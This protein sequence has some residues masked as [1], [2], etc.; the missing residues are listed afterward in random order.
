MSYDEMFELE[1]ELQ[2][3]VKLGKFLKERLSLLWERYHNQ[4]LISI[5]LVGICLVITIW[6]LIPPF[7]DLSIDTSPGMI[8]QEPSL[9]HWLG[10]NDYG[11]DAFNLL[12]TAIRNSIGFGL[13][14]SFIS[15]SIA[16]IFGVIGPFKGGKT[17]TVF[18][19]I[20][21][22][23]LVFPIIPTIILIST[24]TEER[25]MILILLVIALFN[26]P[27]AARSIRAQVLSI[28]ER[29]YIKIAKMSGLSKTRIAISEVIPNVLSYVILSFT[30]ITGIAIQTEAGIAMI[31]LGQ[32]DFIT[33]GYLLQE[34]QRNQYITTG[35]YHLWIPPGIILMLFL[36]LIYAV[37]GSF[38]S[39]FNPKS[40]EKL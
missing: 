2:E 23:A 6:S 30:I 16:V 40:R 36:V 37:H 25:T 3:E 8:L 35:Q 12:L 4:L 26:W 34:A 33:L 1:S 20:T 13:L 24:L 39:T 15:S 17:D 19:F 11:Q 28:K 31:G 9:N 7:N 27:W 21:N 22:I 14:T 10:T 5:F 29:N 32:Q 38:S 18:Q